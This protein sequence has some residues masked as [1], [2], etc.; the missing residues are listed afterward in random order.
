MR[1]SLRFISFEGV[2]SEFNPTESKISNIFRGFNNISYI[3]F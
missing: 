3:S 1:E 2:I